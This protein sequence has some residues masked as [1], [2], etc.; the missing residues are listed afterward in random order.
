MFHP[1]FQTSMDQPQS[2]QV[3]NWPTP[4]GRIQVL[5]ST[6]CVSKILPGGANL[7][8]TPIKSLDSW[9]AQQ[10]NAKGIK[11]DNLSGFSRS[12]TESVQGFSSIPYMLD[13]YLCCMTI[14]LTSFWCGSNIFPPST[15]LCFY[16]CETKNDKNC[17]L[18]HVKVTLWHFVRKWRKK[19]KFYFYYTTTNYLV[20]YI[21]LFRMW[22]IFTKT[23]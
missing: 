1:L 12:L 9:T 21:H 6:C 15:V 22:F 20:P 23:A 5:F 14:W 18:N 17:V 16:F 8:W 3:E 7:V 10:Q 2:P 11:L 4:T 13:V 19:T